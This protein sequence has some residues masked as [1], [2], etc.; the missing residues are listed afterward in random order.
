MAFTDVGAFVCE[1][2]PQ[3][4]CGQRRD[5]AGAEHDPRPP[6]GHAV[7]SHPGM[8]EYGNLADS[9]Q[10]IERR[11]V[12]ADHVEQV[13]HL[14]SPPARFPRERRQ[15][16]RDP[17]G[18]AETRGDGNALHR[19]QLRRTRIQQREQRGQGRM[20][21]GRETHTQQQPDGREPERDHRG[22][23]QQD[24]EVRA[25][26]APGCVEQRGHRRRR[27]HDDERVADEGRHRPTVGPRCPHP[28]HLKSDT[29]PS[30][31]PSGPD[32]SAKP[33]R[34]T[35]SVA[36]RISS[37]RRIRLSS[38]PARTRWC[39]WRGRWSTA[40]AWAVRPRP[41]ARGVA[42]ATGTPP[43]RRRVPPHAAARAMSARLRDLCSGAAR[44]ALAARALAS[45]ASPNWTAERRASRPSPLV[46]FA[47][48]S[49][50]APV[51]PSAER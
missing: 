18:E 24:R 7:R 2:R 47:S 16:E 31:C 1:H 21:N 49:T 11:V 45:P 40:A 23:P 46:P 39:F 44:P 42:A 14:R 36:R 29:M 33:G 3:L 32:L 19:R 20:R 8:F 26:V 9:G 51:V 28:V 41:R 48:C 10:G 25:A 37:C 35:V 22:L 30:W 6:S 13:A 38:P 4:R 17:S 43:H 12:R 15:R 27:N 50:P 5:G 34:G